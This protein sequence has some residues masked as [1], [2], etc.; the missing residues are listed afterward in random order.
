MLMLSCNK[1]FTIKYCLKNWWKKIKHL[2]KLKRVFLPTNIREHTFYKFTPTVNKG[3][4]RVYLV[5][6][7][8]SPQ[9]SARN[10]TLVPTMNGALACGEMTD[11]A[12]RET[13]PHARPTTYKT[14]PYKLRKFRQL[15]DNIIIFTHYNV[16]T[17]YYV[18]FSKY[19][20][21]SYQHFKN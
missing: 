18:V 1:M 17:K 13:P 9:T 4:I 8:H 21:V 5:P 15:M 10:K 3:R 11:E 19:V 20:I 2:N 12:R 14:T 6:G 7:A 16:E